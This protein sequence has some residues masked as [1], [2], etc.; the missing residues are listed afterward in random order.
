MKP[1]VKY[2]VGDGK[3]IFLWHDR[4]WDGGILSETF[5]TESL[6][7]PDSRTKISEMIHNGVWNGLLLIQLSKQFLSLILSHT[8]QIV[9]PSSSP[10]SSHMAALQLYFY[11][12]STA[13]PGLTTP[14]TFCIYIWNE[15][16]KRPLGNEKRSYEEVL[17]MIINNVRMK[18][19]SLTVKSSNKVD[20]VSRTWQI[21][22]N[23]R[24]NKECLIEEWNISMEQEFCSP[25]NDAFMQEPLCASVCGTMYRGR[26][27]AF[28][29]IVVKGEISPWSPRT[30]STNK[31]V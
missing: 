10:T 19:A 11:L 25:L 2:E 24:K 14:P 17:M 8:P 30:S 21:T 18:L 15:R 4:W 23:R 7:N 16:N 20:D 28:E 6:P 9:L 27:F 1:H 26:V 3:S 31:L 29:E 12:H 13:S 22:M 5:P